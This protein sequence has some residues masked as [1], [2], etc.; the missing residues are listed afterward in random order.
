MAVRQSATTETTDS[1]VPE[2]TLSGD[3]KA[4]LAKASRAF[5]RTMQGSPEGRTTRDC[6][7][8]SARLKLRVRS[9][10]V[11]VPVLRRNGYGHGNG[12]PQGAIYN[13]FGWN[14]HLLTAR[15]SVDAYTRSTS[16]KPTD[17]RALA[18]AGYGA[19][20]G[21]KRRAAARLFRGVF[22]ASLA[23]L[24][25]G[26][27]LQGEVLPARGKLREFKT[28]ERVP[29]EV[30]GFLHVHDPTGDRGPAGN[31]NHALDADI[32]GERAMIRLICLSGLAVERFR[33]PDGNDRSFGKSDLFDDRLGWPRGRR[34]LDRRRG[35]RLRNLLLR[36]RSGCGLLLVLALVPRSLMFVRYCAWRR[37]HLRRLRN[38]RRGYSRLLRRLNR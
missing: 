18:S 22:A 35:R 29:F 32:A 14:H 31:G 30:S 25:I 19:D 36:R 24:A 21:S 12:R 38:R 10:P 34:R 6:P 27:G 8:V 26:V 13:G 11:I 4:R 15:G 1:F 33:N 2:T 3:E 20:D 37:S 7:P 28:E 17:G 5:S 16:G 9:V 23:L